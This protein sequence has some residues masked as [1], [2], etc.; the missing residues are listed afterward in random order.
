ME[1]ELKKLWQVRRGYG[2]CARRVF[3]GNPHRRIMKK[4]WFEA[5]KYLVVRKKIRYFAA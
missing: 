1:A 2:R 3:A 5:L 4:Y